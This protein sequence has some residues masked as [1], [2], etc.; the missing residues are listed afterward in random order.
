MATF[1]PWPYMKAYLS[2][3]KALVPE[4]RVVVADDEPRL[5][6]A[7][8]TTLARDFEVTGTAMDGQ[9]L[10]QRICEEEPDV[11]VV[12][13]G[14]PDINGLEITRRVLQ[15]GR[16]PAVVICS[17]EKD[18]ELVHAALEAGACCYVWKDRIACELNSA[19]R[20]AATGKQFTSVM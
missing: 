7:I 8:V 5:L 19:V 9:T 17:V 13:L 14:L 2:S 6:A 10:L 3:S 18:P 16:R 20:L 1:V 4:L 12:D 15:S 11:V